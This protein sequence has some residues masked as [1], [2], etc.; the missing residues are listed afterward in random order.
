[1]KLFM[2][3][4]YLTMALT[5]GHTAFAQTIVGRAAIGGSIVVLF[6]NNTWAYEG[7][8]TPECNT[9]RQVLTFCDPENL[10][11]PTSKSSAQITAAY[12]HDATH[13]SQ[14]IIENVG[15]AEGMSAQ[16]F[17]DAV[18][19]NAAVLTGVTSQDI[20]IIDIYE[21]D[22]SGIPAET[23]VYQVNASG[24]DVV[25]ANTLILEEHYIFQAMT[26]SL[27]TEFLEKHQELHAYLLENITVNISQ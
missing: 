10:W 25:Y 19:N 3:F 24:L 27:G 11:R 12:K 18:I 16:N 23:V 8:E 6:D 26:Y 20:V 7:A 22:V 21:T 17:R 4:I 1:M 9:M 5:F 15:I 2:K 13:Y 14:F